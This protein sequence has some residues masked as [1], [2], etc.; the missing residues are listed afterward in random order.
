MKKTLPVAIAVV[1]L[2]LAVFTRSVPVAGLP[3]RAEGDGY[4]D[5]E[6]EAYQGE[7]LYAD[8]EGGSGNS[9]SG[10]T[11]ASSAGFRA[12]LK[13]SEPDEL[14]AEGAV[15]TSDLPA[16]YDPRDGSPG[17][18]LPALR[19]QSPY[20]TC[21][22][23]GI[24][25]TMEMNLIKKAL[26]DSSVDLSER[27]LLYYMYNKADTPDPLGNTGGDYNQA[28]YKTTGA[29]AY[30]KA[31]GN[32]LLTI[33]HLLS[34][35]GPVKES[36]FP[37][38]AL[39]ADENADA[40]GLGGAG[41]STKAA[42]GMDEAHLQNAYVLSIG[43]SYGDAALRNVMKGMIRQYG[44]LGTGYY[45]SSSYDIPAKDCYYNDSYATGTNHNIT[46]VGW[47]DTFARENFTNGS[48][49]LPDQ[50]GA[51]LVRNSY[52]AESA[53]KA[54]HGYFWM[55]YEDYGLRKVSGGNTKY[56]VAL[57]LEKNDLYDNLYQYDGN[58]DY[59]F[60]PQNP[61][62]AAAI[63]RAQAKNGEILS[64][65]GV[66]MMSAGV[67]YTLSVYL[68]VTEG[69]PQSG[70]LA[71]SQSGTV[72]Y[73]GYTT[74]ELENPVTLKEGQSYSVVLTGMTR[75]SDNTAPV[76]V[77]AC[78][79]QRDLNTLYYNF[80]FVSNTENDKTYYQPE[81]GSTWHDAAK[82]KL[83]LLEGQTINTAFEE[84]S[85]SANEIQSIS[86][87]DYTLRIKA[88]TR[89]VDPAEVVGDYS[90]AQTDPQND[91]SAAKTEDKNLCRSLTLSQTAASAS[92]GG[93][94][95]LVATALSAVGEAGSDVIWISSDPAVAAV[96]DYGYVTMKKPGKAIITASCDGV[97]ARM[98]VTV[99]PGATQFTGAVLKGRT[100]KTAAV[101]LTWK[102]V[103]DADGYIVYRS[104][105]RSKG[106]QTYKTIKGA[107]TLKKKYDALKG[108][109]P[110]YFRIASYVTAADGTRLISAL[111]DPVSI[112][113]DPS[114]FKA[115]AQ[116]GKISKLTWK[117]AAKVAGYE[118]LRSTRKSGGYKRVGSVAVKKTS[119]KTY[120]LKNK[121]PKKGKIYYY[122]LRSFIYI[123]K[124]RIRGRTVA[125]VRVKSK[126]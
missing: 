113:S 60:F 85:V 20:E 123:G 58:A 118:I 37:Y 80:T 44:A 86:R 121:V 82:M 95:Q 61:R 8:T 88:Y 55:S 10:N 4:F 39:V 73:M 93:S 92:V 125:T 38:T 78:S 13:S 19:D 11:P 51:W 34:R 14:L 115:L 81:N 17:Y 90:T 111:S 105:Y 66:G 33:W 36:L 7:I 97:R 84:G 94:L 107:D 89:N 101:S 21:W 119:R 16:V 47:D 32:N 53:S 69:D 26:A 114:G 22:S 96:T 1:C 112:V 74:I 64:A 27:H 72:P 35:C 116:K 2:L 68:D 117:K 59:C 102:K 124:T 18:S 24:T 75:R 46:I 57:D 77:A 41:N 23:F 43:T 25:A 79:E 3:E 49:Q 76:L 15:D 98:E 91:G 71:A 9:V 48:H 28:T 30:L 50:D 52:G 12:L 42:F 106:Y 63:Y 40:G 100:V 83:G 70:T 31:G 110:Y 62:G 87:Q 109:R 108:K 45:A 29:N 126:G 6:E 104:T 54:Q 65:V 99:L 122:R 103:E 120:T 67:D 56:A 5:I